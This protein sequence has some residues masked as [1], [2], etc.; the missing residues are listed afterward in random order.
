MYLSAKI[1][2]PEKPIERIVQTSLNWFGI[3]IYSNVLAFFV[4]ISN[5][6]LADLYS[7]NELFLCVSV[8][9]LKISLEDLTSMLILKF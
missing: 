2:Q 3:I 6:K 1:A 7:R 5:S 8:T 9:E 4:L